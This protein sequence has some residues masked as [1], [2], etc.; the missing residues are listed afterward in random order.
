MEVK[1][2]SLEGIQAL[3]KQKRNLWIFVAF[4][5]ALWIAFTLCA[6]LI[7]NRSTQHLWIILGTVITSLWL[8][9][10]GYVFTKMY[11]PLKH[12]EAFSIQALSKERIINNVRICELHQEVETYKGFRTL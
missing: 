4:I 3:K 8:I 5:S 6:F 11:A 10:L 12:Y 2:I 7:Q 9:A 1:L